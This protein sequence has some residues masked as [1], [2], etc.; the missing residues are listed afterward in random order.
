MF[1]VC[2]WGGVWEGDVYGVRTAACGESYISMLVGLQSRAGPGHKRPRRLPA[3]MIRLF[4][5][6]SFFI[7]ICLFF[8]ILTHRLVQAAERS[9]LSFFLHSV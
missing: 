5:N 2:V 6:V 8:Y 3:S 4:I 1:G 9:A 7:I